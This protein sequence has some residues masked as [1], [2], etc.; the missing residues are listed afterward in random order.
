MSM[1]PRRRQLLRIVGTACLASGTSVAFG[2]DATRGSD[3]VRAPKPSFVLGEEWVA[4]VSV[5]SAQPLIGSSFEF[6][7]VHGRAAAT[8]VQAASNYQVGERRAG[9][10]TESFQLIFEITESTR[11]LPR[12]YCNV[13][14][15]Q[16]GSFEIFVQTT[17]SD[18][19]NDQF[20]ATFNRLGK[21]A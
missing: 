11:N 21:I 1:Q 12:D 13:A 8:L 6:W 20:V 10:T 9:W 19:G 16:L 3:D 14:H 15:P 7:S 17:K 2:A 4:T 18:K 5:E